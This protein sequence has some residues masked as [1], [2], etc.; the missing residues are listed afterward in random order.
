MSEQERCR[1]C[2]APETP[3]GTPHDA[4]CTGNLWETI[5]SLRAQVAEARNAA[6]DEAANWIKARTGCIPGSHLWEVIQERCDSM[7]RS[8]KAPTPEGGK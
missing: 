3:Q 2:G 8:L 5:A 7:L 4:G 6:L 1:E